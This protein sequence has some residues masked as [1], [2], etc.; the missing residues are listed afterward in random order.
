[1]NNYIIKTLYTFSTVDIEANVTRLPNGSSQI[2]F[3]LPPELQD[4]PDLQTEVN[5]GEG[6]IPVTTTH[7]PSSDL[8]EGHQ[9]I[10]RLRLG[11]WTGSANI[12]IPSVSSEEVDSEEGYSLT[13][14]LLTYAIIFGTLLVTCAVMIAIV[15]GLKYIQWSHR[16]RDKSKMLL[17]LLLLFSL[18]ICCFLMYI[19]VTDYREKTRENFFPRLASSFI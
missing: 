17:L 12:S 2:H 11:A 15:L 3:H 16:E 18:C 13:D 1:M 5:L 14:L 10:I 19:S 9:I 7:I 4:E 6:W 8:A